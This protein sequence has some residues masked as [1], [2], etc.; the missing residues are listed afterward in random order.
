MELQAT[1]RVSFSKALAVLLRRTCAAWLA[2]N[3]PRFGAAIAFYTLF[4]LVPVLVITVSVAGSV[5]GAKIAQGEIVAD[6]LVRYLINHPEMDDRCSKQASISFF[7]ESGLKP[8]A[9]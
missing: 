4:A 9:F 3:A 6:S 1:T 8:S 7:T 2:D 5:F